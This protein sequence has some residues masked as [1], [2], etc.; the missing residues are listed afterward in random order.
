M[1]TLSHLFL[2]APEVLSPC[3]LSA[4]R[5]AVVT[6]DADGCGCLETQVPQIHWRESDSPSGRML[7]HRHFHSEFWYRSCIADFH[8]TNLSPAVCDHEGGE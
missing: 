1:G 4:I 7:C 2:R 6:F 5:M 3:S 8:I